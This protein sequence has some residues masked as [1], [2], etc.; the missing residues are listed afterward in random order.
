MFMSPFGSPRNR[1]LNNFLDRQSK[2]G[3]GKMK[4]PSGKGNNGVWVIESLE[5][6]SCLGLLGVPAGDSVMKTFLCPPLVYLSV[7]LLSLSLVHICHF[8]SCYFRKP[9]H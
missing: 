1:I 7:S 6:L 3:D 5:K 2:G 9:K 4:G 8:F